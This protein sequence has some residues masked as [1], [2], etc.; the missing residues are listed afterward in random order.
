M[1]DKNQNTGV[2]FSS[3]DVQYPS[4]VGVGDL[5]L[6]VDSLEQ[7][8][9]Y[10][11]GG[12]TVPGR[13]PGMMVRI[14]RRVDL[15][16]VGLLVV[17]AIGLIVANNIHKSHVKSQQSISDRYSSV[18]LPLQQFLPT[19]NG[20]SLRATSVTINGSLKLNDGLVISP[21]VQPSAPS[22]GQLYFDRNTNELA[23]YNGTAFVPLSAQTQGVQSVGGATGAITLGGGL[24]V[25]GNQLVSVNNGVTSFGGQTGAITV[26][27]GLKMSGNALQ[28]GG[29]L[30]V[31]AGSNITVTNDGNGNYTVNNV[32]AG[33]GTVTSPGGTA[34]Q[35][36]MFDGAQDIVDSLITQ[37]GTSVTITGD[38]AVVTGGLSLSNALTVSNGGTGTTSLSANGVVVSNGTA[39][40]SSI[41]A[42]G[43]GLCLMSTV[44]AP[45]FSACPGAS[46]VTTL[47]GLSGALIIANAG[48][49]GSTITINDATTGSKGIASFNPTNF[50][51]SGGAVNTIQDINTTAAPTFGQLT[52]SSSQA[53]GPMLLINNTNAGASGN[54][55]DL[56][57]N[58]SSKFSVQPNGNVTG[59]GTINGQTISNAAGFS[60]TL[61]VAGNTTLSGDVAVN[62]GDI[63]ST[64]ALNIT[65]TGTL[66][67]G[68]TTQTLTL[69]GGTGTTLKAVSGAN[70][71]TLSFQAPTAVVTYRFATAAAGSYDV[72]TTAGNCSGLGGSVTTA[73]GTTNKLAKFSGAQA[74]ADSSISDNG[75]TVTTTANIVIQGGN[76]AVGV[77]NSQTGSLS[78]AY[79]SANFSGTVTQGALTAS[80]TYTLPDAD[81]TVCLSSGNCLGGG[82]GGANTALSNLSSVAINT[83]LL[84]GSTSIDLGSGA[85]PFRNLFISGASA[86]PA[87]NNFEI[88]GTATAARTITLP[89]QSGTVCL[90]NSTNCGFL[91][92]TGTAFVQNGNSFGATGVLGTSDGFGLNL[93]TSGLPRISIAAAGDTSFSGNVAING[94]TL[95]SGSALNVTPGGTLTVGSTVQ[96]LTLQGNTS[97]T[98]SATGN[99]HI[100]TVGFNGVATADVN[101]NFDRTVAAG[102][103]T[104]CSTIGN[105]AG[106]G[107]GV[108]SA[109]GST[110]TIAVFTASQ[111]IGNSLLSQSGGTVTVNGNNNL[112]G[113][114]QYQINGAQISSANLSN[115]SNLAKLNASET[116]TGATLSF[117]NAGSDS[118]NAF[119]V[120]NV[121][122]NALLTANTTSGSIILGTAS[123][124]DGKLVFNNVSNANTVTV[125]PGTPTAARTITLPNASGTVCLDSGN[126]VGAGATLQ[127]AYNFSSG[128][129]TPKIKVDNTLKGLDIQD[130]DTT[131]AADLLDV[132]AS[133]GAGL[134]QVMFGVGNTGATTFQNSANSALAL[135]VLT[136]GGTKVFTV[137][138]NG[139]RGVLGQSATLTGQLAFNN[140]TNS[141]QVTLTTAAATAAR[142]ATLPDETGTV[143]L[144]NSTNCGFAIV[145]G[146]AAYIQNQFASAQTGNYFVQGNGAGNVV[147]KVQAASG[148]TADIFQVLASGGGALFQISGNTNYATLTDN[149]SIVG[150]GVA[151]KALEVKSGTSSGNATDIITSFEK[152]D[153]T[154][155]G[156]MTNIG[157]GLGNLVNLSGSLS[158][159]DGAGGHSAE[160]TPGTLTASRNL[161]LPDASG[162]FCLQSSAACGFALGSG[163]AFVQNGNSFGATGV[164]G[165]IDANN[166]QFKTN[167]VVRATFDQSNGLYLGNGITNA[168]P[169]DFTIQ[170]TG[171]SG[172]NVAGAAISIASGA[173]TGNANS[174][175][176]N[177]QVATPG[178]SGSSANVPTTVAIISGANGSATFKNAINSTTGFQVQN[179]GGANILSVNT[180]TPAVTVQGTGAS[181]SGSLLYFGTDGE[182]SIGEAAG[183]PDILTYDARVGHSFTIDGTPVA[184]VGQNGS[185]SVNAFN[186]FGGLVVNDAA[187]H[188][189]FNVVGDNSSVQIGYNG[190]TVGT[191]LVLDTK[192]NAGDPTGINGGMYYNANAN[193]FRCY[194]NSG[195]TDCIATASGVTTVGTLD[196]QTKSADGAVITGSSLVLQSADAT[197]V[198]LITAGVQT[199]AGDKTFND[200]I[201]LATTANLTV[202]NGTASFNSGGSLDAV[203]VVPTT[204][205]GIV[206]DHTASGTT[207]NGILIQRTVGTITTGLGFS[208]TI[209]TDIARGSGTLTIQGSGATA[210][211]SVGSSTAASTVDIADTSNG[212]GTQVV[213]I[214]SN[215]KTA[216]TVSIQGGNLTG[217]G[218]VSIGTVGTSAVYIGSTTGTSGVSIS[219]GTNNVSIDGSQQINIGQGSATTI[220]IG[221]VNSQ[222]ITIGPSGLTSN[223]NTI[224]IGVGGIGGSQTIAIGSGLNTSSLSLSAGRNGASIQTGTQSTNNSGVITLQ[225]GTQ[226]GNSLQSG[227]I[228]ITTGDAGGGT[229]SSSGAITIDSGTKSGSGTVGA[230]NIGTT[231]ATTVNIGR[232]ASG[233]TATT[234]N[235]TVTIKP[236]SGNDSTTAI[237]LQ[238]GAGASVL[239]VDT[240]TNN[241]SVFSGVGTSLGTWTTTS[242]INGGS[243]AARYGSTSVTANGYVYVLGGTSNS[244]SS[245]ANN[246]YYAKINA[247]G[248]ISSTWS[249]ATNLPYSAYKA[250]SVTANG[251]IYYIGGYDGSTHR[252][253]VSYAKIN[254]DGS[255]GIW[256]T[257]TSLSA[258]R[259]Y[260]S[261]VYLN[262]YVYVI[263]GYN[264]TVYLGSTLYAK[265]NAD[266]TV[267]SWSTATGVLPSSALIARTS[268]VAANGYIYL[269]GGSSD[270]T[271]ANGKTAVYY[272]QPNATTGD[273]GS[274]WSTSANS[275]SASAG[276]MGGTALVSNGR[277]YYMGGIDTSSAVQTSIYYASLP[278]GGGD[279]GAWST[280]SSVLGAARWDAMSIIVNGY[281]YEIGGNSSGAT[282]T[283]V[284]TIYYATT[285]RIQLGGSLDLVGLQ[286]ATLADNGS[287]ASAGTTGGSITAGNA[288]FVGSM[289]VMGQAMFRQNISA[290]SISIA[291]VFSADSSQDVIVIG[292]ST[293]N[294]TFAAST[295]EPTLNGTARHTRQVTVP[296]EYAGASM[297]GDG[298]NNSGTMTSDNMTSSPYRNY[299]KWVNTQGTAQDYDI[300]VKVPLPS[301]FAALPSGQTICLDVFASATT[302]NTIALTLYGTNN[303]SVSLSDGDLTPSSTSTWQ[304]QCT[305]SITGGTF[306]ANGTMTLDFKLTAPATTGDVRIGDLAF[307]YLSKW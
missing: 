73:G 139:S 121:A 35:I 225:T 232:T 226:T 301:D 143:C 195:W 189:I 101:Y 298:S 244:A 40:F 93:T 106:S 211:G 263:G 31:V 287:D 124:L 69:Q 46:G 299:Y 204:G 37:S 302:A 134:G 236:I 206:V 99:S 8:P 146:S 104:I 83:S 224:N 149:L 304:N 192:T 201:T 273:I 2:G 234:I 24:A 157:L 153:G 58:G 52:L 118:V 198:G 112:T 290:G 125:L 283:S 197:H 136:Q 140:S 217:G 279:I 126:C 103:Y 168:T 115:D 288:V 262:G 98:L 3:T 122:G 281:M 48:A 260:A 154:V 12:T 216:N 196:S 255:L 110:G 190:D 59:T 203:T 172:T 293:N 193:K 6:P 284:S 274:N 92:G 223:S 79:G 85:A 28:N 117:K 33:T 200:D 43:A 16:L 179:Q 258:G 286:S 47:N 300:W 67:T 38:L 151:S 191:Q 210:I 127:T 75:T 181:G 233:N 166:L 239:N 119:N 100:T 245:F 305:S 251:Y 150:Q 296:A 30:S 297:T 108:T 256:Q 42:G 194:Q 174:G 22:S 89:D 13:R 207:P 261:S 123:T 199:L 94:S 155:V 133:N 176:L 242:A 132:R 277:V 271:A 156:Q 105:C 269:M 227:A 221:G 186:S 18:Q 165:T 246:V 220:G 87:S 96:T 231:N 131:I 63:T 152:Q 21:S 175:N 247:D 241:I 237:Q 82:G 291:G 129:T 289:Q 270:N 171:G 163:T 215:A 49:A 188:P 173:G 102:T 222:T 209:G 71:T 7:D 264:G 243:P 65:P 51:T 202:S 36:T 307:S 161:A 177:F 159:G 120:Q 265:I 128:G 266:G 259:A 25:V 214:G 39:A 61:G 9:A 84:P 77:A 70:S 250:T 53:G 26:G 5:S 178:L 76:A 114:N 187:S 268:V 306:A 272:V 278:A 295:H 185:L 219:G 248:T 205:N 213:T 144:Q 282:T 230:I 182:I 45:A 170:G 116:F 218:G 27:A 17:G 19:E 55:L 41:T 15:I 275:L 249:S 267:G 60:G 212:T 10:T 78:L 1:D 292:D 57:L 29:A 276:R 169:S 252:T 285:A 280:S 64:G 23:Y 208:G 20:L 95:S 111:S 164:L 147:A 54:L 113:G 56:Q 167:S 141:N 294:M 81:G 240:T 145:S 62:G 254:A 137:D 34:G 158:F 80:R 109:G 235:G 68:S 14:L 257:G 130:A 228:S 135:Q 303:S 180:T 11:Q 238:N 229:N 72:C 74:I 32:G 50:S 160:I 184:T 162:T 107:A 142:T 4:S 97:T 86:S 183:N 91:T 138:T 66:T 253:D 44:G 148:Q 88:T 90:N